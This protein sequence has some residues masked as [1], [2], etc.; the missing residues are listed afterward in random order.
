MLIKTIL[1]WLSTKKLNVSKEFSSL[2]KGSFLQNQFTNVIKVTFYNY[3]RHYDKV[4][5][6]HFPICELRVP[7]LWNL[8]INGCEKSLKYMTNIWEDLL[9]RHETIFR[10]PSWPILSEVTLPRGATFPFDRNFAGKNF[11]VELGWLSW[12]WD[13]AGT[14]KLWCNSFLLPCETLWLRK[15]LYPYDVCVGVPGN[16]IWTDRS[17]IRNERDI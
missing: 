3:I 17:R 11:S 6:S 7:L 8:S 1:G 15:A 13:I 10:L 16:I 14:K 9:P 2:I 12:S 5:R 4:Y